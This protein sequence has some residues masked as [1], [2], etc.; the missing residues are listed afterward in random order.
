MIT[1]ALTFLIST[2]LGLFSFALLLRFYLQAAR[3]PAR[4]PVS[5]FVVALTDFIVRPA[6]RYIPGWAGMDLST[7]VLAWFTEFLLL[8]LVRL[9][10]GGAFGVPVVGFLLLAVVSIVRMSIYI[11]MGA[12]II[13]AILSWIAPYSPVA[14]VANSVTRPFLRPF[15]RWVPPVGNVDLSPLVLLIVLQLI[16]MVPVRWLEGAVRYFLGG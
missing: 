3:A 12:L 4:N 11:L 9:V 10:Q 16:L 2:I 13:Q 5:Q 8:L 6:R 1:E 14:P 15:Q 7:L